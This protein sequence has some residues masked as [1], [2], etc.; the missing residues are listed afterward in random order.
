MTTQELERCKKAAKEDVLLF[1]KWCRWK[2]VREKVLKMDKYEC[3]WC[4]ENKKYTPATVVHHIK[5]FEMHPEMALSIFYI[6]E[7]GEK[8]RNLIS[9]CNK[10]HNKAHHRF[11]FQQ[12]RKGINKLIQEERWD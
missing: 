2:K 3:Q 4:K 10:C 1:Y 5:E 9:L 6:D 11:E 8:Q 12:K 7:N